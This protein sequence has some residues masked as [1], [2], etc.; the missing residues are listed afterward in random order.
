MG[1]IKEIDK[2]T[3]ITLKKQTDLIKNS[4]SKLNEAEEYLNRTD[5]V[6][7]NMIKRVFTNKL[8]LFALIILL[9]VLNLFILGIKLR[10]KLFGNK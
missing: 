3:M 8:V 5:N 10:T 6:L 9:A 4:T 2:E 1:N 7:N